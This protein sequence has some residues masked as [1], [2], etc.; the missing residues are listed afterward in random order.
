MSSDRKSPELGSVSQE[1]RRMIPDGATVVYAY[2]VAT[3]LFWKLVFCIEILEMCDELLI[4]S[5]CFGFY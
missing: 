3:S 4:V 1:I 5:K 2:M